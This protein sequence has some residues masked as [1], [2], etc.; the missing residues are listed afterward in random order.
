MNGQTRKQRILSLAVVYLIMVALFVGGVGAVK[1]ACAQDIKQDIKPIDMYLIGGQSNASGYSVVKNVSGEFS[2]IMYIGET[3]KLL[4]GTNSYYN[5]LDN[6]STYKKYVT[7]GYGASSNKIGPEFGMAKQLDQHYGGEKKA[8]IFKSAA[9]G[10]SI[11]NIKSNLSGL[12][13]NW[14]PRSMWETGFTP[15]PSVSATGV[16]YKNFVDNFR[17]VYNTLKE[18]GYSPKVRGMA[19]MQGEE[20]LGYAN[21][22]KTLIKAFINDIREDIAGITGD[23]TDLLMPFVI[24]EIA[25]TFGSYDNSSVPPFNK[26]Q[27]EVAA[28]IDGVYTIP[29]SD[30]I[31]VGKNGIEGTDQYHFGDKDAVTL[32]ERFG[33]KLLSVGDETLVKLNVVGKNGTAKYNI[34]E[35]GTELV[36]DLKP[37]KNY[38]VSSVKVNETEMVENVE[39][40]K[41]V[42]NVSETKKFVITVEFGKKTALN[43][44]VESDT[45]KGKV[46]KDAIYEGDKI[47]ITVT[48]NAG[49]KVKSVTFNDVALTLNEETGMYES[50][51]VTTGGTIKVD[52]EEVNKEQESTGCGKSGAATMACA[53]AA[54]VGS[55]FLIKRY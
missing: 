54:L 15:D 46:Q 5:T 18:N 32:G 41:L 28:E 10:T 30:L 27:R 50:E 35:S 24:G 4:D 37:N 9:G 7:V 23:D 47:M 39:N 22:Y 25:T 44:K 20:D 48:P 12:Y 34:S 16:Q 36:V 1:T 21:E 8:I 31:I 19:W 43:I 51:P 38:K 49:Y 33:E 26:M 52:Y 53:L 13:G 17:T 11:R 29:T 14:Y 55:L 6:F 3:E 2:N 42:L 40:N 45:Y